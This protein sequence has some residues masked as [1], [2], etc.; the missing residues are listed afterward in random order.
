M[1]IFVTEK[2]IW[3]IRQRSLRGFDIDRAGYSWIGFRQ[4]WVGPKPTIHWN[5]LFSC[6]QACLG[7]FCDK[8]GDKDADGDDK[9]KNRAPIL[10]WNTDLSESF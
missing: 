2:G 4:R 8:D 9:P 10:S 1:A 7:A 6:W 3:N 5:I